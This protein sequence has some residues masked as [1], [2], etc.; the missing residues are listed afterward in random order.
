MG[1]ETFTKHQPKH[2][3]TVLHCGHLENKPHHFFAM[4]DPSLGE[5]EEVM[6]RRPN[7]TTGRA[8][9]MVLCSRCILQ[10]SMNPN[11]AMR[12]DATWIGDEPAI[13]ENVQ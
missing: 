12:A 8:R 9:W 13:K 3:E 4:S 5:P 7:G 6:F 11:L 1:S 10:H 2:G